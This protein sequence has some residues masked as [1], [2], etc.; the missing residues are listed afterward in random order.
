MDTINDAKLRQLLDLLETIE[1]SDLPTDSS[2]ELILSKYKRIPK[3]LHTLNTIMGLCKYLCVKNSYSEMA[4]RILRTKGYS[5]TSLPSKDDKYLL[6]T[7]KGYFL[8]E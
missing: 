4:V 7:S 1:K 2:S 3:D 6:E 8:I 5:C